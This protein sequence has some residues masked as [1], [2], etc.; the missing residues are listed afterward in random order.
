LS[1]LVFNE[2]FQKMGLELEKSENDSDDAKLFDDA[3]NLTN[4]YSKGLDNLN[5][6]IGDLKNKFSITPAGKLARG[7]KESSQKIK[8][9][10]NELQIFK[11]P[12]KMVFEVNIKL[13][14]K[15]FNSF[16]V[17]IFN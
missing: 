13:I 8:K 9:E 2:A 3:T 10:Q 15:N 12:A 4:N 17:R 16:E 6:I 11:L 5:L 1:F 14:T 7:M